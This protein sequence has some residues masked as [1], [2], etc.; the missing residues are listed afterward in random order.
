MW[1]GH[2]DIWMLSLNLWSNHFWL[3]DLHLVSDSFFKFPCLHWI[4]LCWLLNICHIFDPCWRADLI[5]IN[6]I[7]SSSGQLQYLYCWLCSIGSVR[8]DCIFL[9]TW[10]LE[11]DLWSH[12]PL[13]VL[14]VVFVELTWDTVLF[15]KH[16]FGWRTEV[17]VLNCMEKKQM[18]VKPFICNFCRADPLAAISI[19]EFTSTI[20]EALGFIFWKGTPLLTL[21]MF[22]LSFS[23][24]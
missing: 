13:S 1:T 18:W 17:Y 15:V 2:C 5:K 8:Q 21:T 22:T 11:T 19:K 7:C 23:T 16:G 3:L 14:S 9:V 10:D 6:D 24:A 4:V 12:Q 20:S